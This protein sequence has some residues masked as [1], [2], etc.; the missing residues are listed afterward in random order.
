MEVGT[1]G[2]LRGQRDVLIE[3]FSTLGKRQHV[4]D[5][6]KALHLLLLPC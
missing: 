5:G 2:A 6:A 3:S 4:M 1:V